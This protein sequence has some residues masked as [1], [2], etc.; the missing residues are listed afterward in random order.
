MRLQILVTAL[1]L[2]GTPAFAEGEL[3]MVCRVKGRNTRTAIPSGEIISDE[4]AVDT[5][6]FKFDMSNK[7]LINH[8]DPTLADFSVKGDK[9]IQD[10]E[11]TREGFVARLHGEF[12]LNPPGPFVV[13]N[14]WR[15]KAEYQ[16]IKGQGDCRP[17]TRGK[18][19]EIMEL[20]EKERNS[21]K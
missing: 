21:K 17:L 18:W 6:M 2:T 5:L 13:D 14:W 16:V 1:F 3:Y 9:L 10:T 20:V 19:D 15:N 11:I 4:V 12:P 8:R 7:T